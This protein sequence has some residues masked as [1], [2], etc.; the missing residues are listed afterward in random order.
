M[1]IALRSTDELD[2]IKARKNA[3][4]GS[5]TLLRRM[6]EHH[7]VEVA[8]TVDIA[9]DGQVAINEKSWEERQREIHVPLPVAPPKLCVEDIQR[10]CGQYFKISKSALLG[11]DRHKEV[12]YPRH[13]AMYLARTLTRRSLPEIGRRFGGRD[14][15]TVM[16]GIKRITDLIRADWLIAY[17]VAQLEAQ[18]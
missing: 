16:H 11:L 4:R 12:A 6:Q 14:H 1:T 9:D 10:V 2:V 7:G 8:I 13:V 3:Y 5:Q 18:L 15:T 17:D